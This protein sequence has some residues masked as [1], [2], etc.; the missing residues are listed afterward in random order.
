[1][2]QT[3]LKTALIFS[4][5]HLFSGPAFCQENSQFNPVT[6]SKAAVILDA[7]RIYPFY[8]GYAKVEK[9]NLFG[10]IDRN[11]NFILP[12]G[13][14]RFNEYENYFV[15]DG[16]PVE[17]TDFF[18][19][20]DEKKEQWAF[21]GKSGKIHYLPKKIYFS[22]LFNK[23]GNAL[24][25]SQIYSDKNIYIV[26]SVGK[27]KTLRPLPFTPKRIVDPVNDKPEVRTDIS[28][29]YPCFDEK[30]TYQYGYV[31][32]MTGK[33][34]IQPSY[35]AVRPFFEGMAAVAQKDKFGN[36][37]WG[38][39]D[40]SGKLV[41]PFR[42]RNEPERFSS[43]LSKVT[44]VDKSDYSVAFINKKG[45]IIFT[46]STEKYSTSINQ[47]PAV[48]PFQMGYTYFMGKRYGE[49]FYIVDT[50]GNIVSHYDFLARNG[51]QG[52][53]KMKRL[54]IQNMVNG[55]LYLEASSGLSGT[56][57]FDFAKNQFNILHGP[58]NQRVTEVYNYDHTSGL[59]HFKHVERSNNGASTKETEGYINEKNEFVILLGKGAK[60]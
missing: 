52:L 38:F 5:L 55:K 9:G 59:R 18:K 28:L 41:I 60:W 2:Q 3:F 24:A 12:Y 10:V 27:I 17:F 15:N 42:Y 30:T 32:L 6:I 53:E 47:W 34:I 1:M 14:Y 35:S 43:G 7:E 46:L 48:K 11:G 58:T 31:N 51:L 49:E 8:N 40:V 13:N 22:T 57:V 19:F 23:E 25:R 37:L 26:D 36:E 54:Y 45:E 16:N 29:P 21:I 20:Y 56:L 44:A 33:F 39:I 50:L 4:F